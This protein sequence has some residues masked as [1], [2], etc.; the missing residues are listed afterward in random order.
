MTRKPTLSH[1]EINWIVRALQHRTVALQAD[2]ESCDE[3]S[4]AWNLGEIALRNY[5]DLITKLNDIANTECKSVRII[6]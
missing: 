2:M 6:A 5:A 1:T 3:N 4:P